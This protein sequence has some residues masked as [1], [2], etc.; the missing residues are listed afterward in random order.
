MSETAERD[1]VASADGAVAR[2]VVAS[3]HSRPLE[4]P[5]SSEQHRLLAALLDAMIARFGDAADRSVI[6]SARGAYDERRGCVFEDEPLWEAWSQAFLEWYVTER[7]M[8]AGEFDGADPADIERGRAPAAVVMRE[9]RARGDDREADAAWALLRSYRSLFEVR[10]M[11]SGRVELE[12]LIGA[13]LFSVR[14]QRTMAGVSVG[15]VAEMR[16]IGFEGEVLFGRTFCFHPAGTRAPIV[17]HLQ[18]LRA[19]GAKRAEMLDLCARLRI[20]CER[21]RHVSPTRIYAAA[22]ELGP[23]GGESARRR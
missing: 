5:A 1:D 15:D 17:A 22:E 12:D 2:Q 14:E 9:A 3:A 4:L 23:D 19:A 8:C 21:Y 6:A 7:P 16:L 13:G 20:R 11:R 10:S 18:R